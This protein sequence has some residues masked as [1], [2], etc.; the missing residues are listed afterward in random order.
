MVTV[1]YVMKETA[2]RSDIIKNL[3]KQGLYADPIESYCTPGFPDIVV[4]WKGQ[5]MYIET[6]VD[7][8]KFQKSQ[9][10]KYAEM[11]KGEA[12]IRVLMRRKTDG[13]IFGKVEKWSLEGIIHNSITVENAYQWFSHCWYIKKKSR[14]LEVIKNE[15]QRL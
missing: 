14:L 6:K 11:L 1:A 3:R 2:F 7:A 13:Y 4:D 10:P 8:F 9:G 5:H 12:H 15:M